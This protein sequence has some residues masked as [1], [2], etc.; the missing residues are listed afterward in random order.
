MVFVAMNTLDKLQDLF[1]INHRSG[2]ILLL[3]ADCMEVMKHIKDGEFE[4]SCVDP[5]YGGGD[6]SKHTPRAKG[7]S[8]NKIHKDTTW[9]D[10]PTRS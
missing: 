10:A 9:N 8:K 6:I 2:N 3:N 7:T 5:P 1:P 4:L